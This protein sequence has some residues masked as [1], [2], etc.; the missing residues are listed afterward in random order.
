M[1]KMTTAL[2]STI[3]SIGSVLTVK[4]ILTIAVLFL[5]VSLLLSYVMRNEIV[6]YNADGSIA[7]KGETTPKLKWGFS[8]S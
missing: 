2:P 1:T 6:M 8:K 5:I 7:Q 4:N 3:K